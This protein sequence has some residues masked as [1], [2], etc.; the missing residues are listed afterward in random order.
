M[1]NCVFFRENT[2]FEERFLGVKAKFSFFE[3]LE[4]TLLPCPKNQKNYKKSEKNEK[5]YFFDRF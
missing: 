4:N 1:Q 2:D 3:K 5:K